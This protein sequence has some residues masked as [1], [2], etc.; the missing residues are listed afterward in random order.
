MSK[1]VFVVNTENDASK[2]YRQMCAYLTG[3]YACEVG[4]DY[5]RLFEKETKKF[6]FSNVEDVPDVDGGLRPVV[7]WPTYGW[8]INDLGE[9][10]P[11]EQIKA[12]E[13]FAQQCL[14]QTRLPVTKFDPRNFSLL[15][16]KYYPANLSVGIHFRSIPNDDQLDMMRARAIRF[17][18]KEGIN[19]T[20]F[21]MLRL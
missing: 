21:E 9:F 4:A 7:T 20:G 5:A 2:F 1:F 19:I 3:R 12:E 18:H 11:K 10:F 14:Q 16:S 17:A 8:F 13:K 6:P 15:H